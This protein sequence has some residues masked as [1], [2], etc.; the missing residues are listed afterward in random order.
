[1]SAAELRQAA[2][3]LL[4]R[5]AGATSGP[6]SLALDPDTGGRNVVYSEF[7][8]TRYPSIS[9]TVA[10]IAP[11]QYPDGEGAAEWGQTSDA[12]LIATFPPEVVDA[13]ASWLIAEAEWEESVGD[14]PDD[15]PESI[16]T[17]AATFARLING[18]AS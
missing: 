10:V 11:Q 8:A 1:M 3:T 13:L 16:P 18:G 9:P 12:E 2:E 7:V 6:W 17:A 4:A 5:A 15:D 14:L